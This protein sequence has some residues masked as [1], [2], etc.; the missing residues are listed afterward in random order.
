MRL[1]LAILYAGRSDIMCVFKAL[2]KHPEQVEQHSYI[3]LEEFYNFYEILDLSWKK[4][5]F[6]VE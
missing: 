1:F 2:H 6:N 4:V 3:S 5:K